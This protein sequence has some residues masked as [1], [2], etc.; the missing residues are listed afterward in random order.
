MSSAPFF[1]PGPNV[2]WNWSDNQELRKMQ[3]H[4]GIILKTLFPKKRKMIVF[5]QLLGKVEVVPP[6]DNYRQASVIEYSIVRWGMLFSVQ[7]VQVVQ[8][9][10]QLARV[11]IQLIHQA[12]ELCYFCA[13]FHQHLEGL[14]ELLLELFEYMP[15]D[16]HECKRLAYLF[17]M[18]YTLGLHPDQNIIFHD[19]LYQLAQK[20]VDTIAV[21]ALDLEIKEEIV[22]WMR[23]SLKTHP[24]HTMFKTALFSGHPALAKPF[25]FAQE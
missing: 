7:E 13:P 17:K 21:S 15:A 11:D 25:D 16:N 1:I 3:R 23:C 10:L 20:S 14:F 9:P 6:S 18:I 5:D 12:V 19:W 2:R 22:A 8:V 4:S 24:L